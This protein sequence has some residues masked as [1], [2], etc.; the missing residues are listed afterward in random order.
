MSARPRGSRKPPQPPKVIYLQWIG[1]NKDE[2]TRAEIEA[3]KLGND[4]SHGDVTW[5]ADKQY[6]TDIKY[7]RAK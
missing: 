2:L 7:V 3:A 4:T 1:V 6:D 5:C